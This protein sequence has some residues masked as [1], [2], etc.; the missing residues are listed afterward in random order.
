MVLKLYG[1][2]QSTCTKRVAVVLYEKKIPFE[3]VVIDLF[4]GEHKAPTFLEKQRFGQ[5]PYIDD[6]GFTF[7][8]SRAI[9][10]YLD[11]KYPNQ[12]PKL[13]PDSD[14]KAKALFEQGVSIEQSNFDPFA[15]TAT[16][17]AIFKSMLG[18]TKNDAVYDESIKTL[19]AKLDAY[20]KI[21][22]EQKYMGGDELTLADLFH[23]PSG[24]LL[25]TA[26]SD[27]LTSKG[28][29][30]T[31]WWND[32]SSRESWA[33]IAKGVPAGVNKFD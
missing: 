14:L 3:L 17:E 18:Q 22:A 5:V 15:S 31:R 4:K 33:A 10:R 16:F 32:I 21:L 28:P 12:G 6:D 1:N 24:S 25:A 2:P 9:C 30:V 29:N 19:S 26:G 7:F 8:E 13:T 20:E 27:L 11:A 23:L